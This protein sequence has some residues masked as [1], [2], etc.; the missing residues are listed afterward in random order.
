[1]VVLITLGFLR[2]RLAEVKTEIAI[3]SCVKGKTSLEK[4]SEIAGV[5]L[6]AFLM[7]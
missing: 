3:E 5:S 1:M 6:W 4:S 7:S 2:E